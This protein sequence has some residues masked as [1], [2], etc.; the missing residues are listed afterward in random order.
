MKCPTCGNDTRYDGNPFRPFCS[1]RCKLIDLGKWVS[2]AV[3]LPSLERP[4]QEGDPEPG[5]DDV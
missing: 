5:D 3:R 2:E 4:L 1:D